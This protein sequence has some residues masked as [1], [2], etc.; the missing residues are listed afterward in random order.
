ME[1]FR[2]AVVAEDTENGNDG[3]QRGKKPETESIKY[4]GRGRDDKK[5]KDTCLL[6]G[7][8]GTMEGK[9]LP[10]WQ[11]L[12]L[13]VIYSHLSQNFKINGHM[14]I[15]HFKTLDQMANNVQCSWLLTAR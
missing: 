3:A 5:A 11:D 1:Y 13:L 4:V 9:E 7:K 10:I 2:I 8:S 6:I 15:F 12:A 14:S